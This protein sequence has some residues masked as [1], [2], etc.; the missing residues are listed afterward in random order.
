[1]CK[2]QFNNLM[3]GITRPHEELRRYELFIMMSY[4]VPT[5]PALNTTK[6]LQQSGGGKSPNMHTN[7]GIE[8]QDP[9][10]KALGDDDQTQNQQSCMF[11]KLIN[12]LLIFPST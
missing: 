7:D 8:V 3:H 9:K 2:G 11:D 1:M 4:E 6:P 5:N 10:E 12:N